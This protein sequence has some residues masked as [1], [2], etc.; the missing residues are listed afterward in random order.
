VIKEKLKKYI[1]ATPIIII[2]ITLIFGTK[3]PYFNL[4]FGAYY[5]INIGVKL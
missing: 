5:V 2:G 4:S 1:F 3:Y